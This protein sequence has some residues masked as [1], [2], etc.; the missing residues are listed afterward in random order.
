[1]IEVPVRLRDAA[2]GGPQGMGTLLTWDQMMT[3]KTVYNL[4]PE[5]RRRSRR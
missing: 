3:K 5:V 4:H 2:N 1:M